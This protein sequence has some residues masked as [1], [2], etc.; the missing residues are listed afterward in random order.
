M[1]MGPWPGTYANFLALKYPRTI[2]HVV[3]K[4]ARWCLC[5]DM[6]QQG[7]NLGHRVLLHAPIEAALSS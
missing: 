3:D 2:V 6:G 5:S 7:I 1:G 4:P